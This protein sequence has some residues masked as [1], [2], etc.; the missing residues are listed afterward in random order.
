MNR[1]RALL[2]AAALAA[3]AF[4]YL[5]RHETGEGLLGRFGIKPPEHD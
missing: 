2:V 1:R 3:L 5:S 4:A